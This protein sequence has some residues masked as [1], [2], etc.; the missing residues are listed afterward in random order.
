MPRHKAKLLPERPGIS[1]LYFVGMGSYALQDVFMKEVR[2]IQR[3]FDERFDTRGRS[4]S[5]INNE[6]TAQIYVGKEMEGKLK[7]LERLGAESMSFHSR[8]RH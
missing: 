2:Y 4:V 5:L 1:D 8:L 3:Q 6:K 7:D